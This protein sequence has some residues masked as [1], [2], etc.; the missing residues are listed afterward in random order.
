MHKVTG[1]NNNMQPDFANL[2]PINTPNFVTLKPGYDQSLAALSHSQATLDNYRMQAQ[3]AK[4]QADQAQQAI[5]GSVINTP[6][7]LAGGFAKGAADSLQGLGKLAMKGITSLIPGK[8][9]E[10]LRNSVD[11]SG[12]PD[13]VLKAQNPT[14]MAGKVLGEVAPIGGPAKSVTELPKAAEAFSG[15]GKVAQNLAIGKDATKTLE[16][17]SNAEAQKFIKGGKTVADVAQG[18]QK[19]IGSFVQ[20][21][22]DA[23]KAVKDSIPH[24]EVDPSTIAQKVN[25][26]VMNSIKS[27]AAYKGVTGDVESMFKSP[28][29]LIDSGLLNEEEV[30]KVKGMVNAIS[31]WKD[32]SARGVLN[33]KEQLGSFYKDGLGNSNAILKNIQGG[34]KDIVGDV[35]PQ[36]KPALQKASENIDKADEFTR[37][38]IGKDTIQGETKLSSLAR[39][40]TD[41]TKNAEK[42]N[43]L[44]DLKNLTGHDAMPELKGYS[45]YQA[46]L[47]KGKGDIRD[48][49]T[50]TGTILKNVGKRVGIGAGIGV[51]LE[52]LKK[53]FGI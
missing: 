33:L 15:V 25:E 8:V 17:L 13:D 9:G 51:G 1:K 40:I 46:L 34:L 24:V 37:N 7:N 41:P 2:K 45:D 53:L 5:P 6:S 38:L 42:L 35:A 3:Q 39:N 30:G 21:S 43:L 22:K 18:T 16:Q 20:N 11:S 10:T 29:D 19:A 23:L 28:K 32:T 31:N 47:A 50:K 36:I 49:P 27:N 14:E 44:E 52:E 4:Q 48:I 26:G 12:I